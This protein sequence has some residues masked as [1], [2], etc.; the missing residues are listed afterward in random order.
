VSEITLLT[1]EV[2]ASFR[3]ESHLGS[4]GFVLRWGN[5]SWH[6]GGLI[7]QVKDNNIAEFKALETVLEFVQM[8][9]I[10]PTYLLIKCDSQYV[11]DRMETRRPKLAKR[12]WKMIKEITENVE[13]LKIPRR[14]NKAADAMTKF[15]ENRCH[16]DV[17]WQVE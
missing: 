13:L 12:C 6:Q 10:Q 7:G 15:Y 4:Y 17:P 1:I 16:G 14:H 9:K 8:F 2:D 5:E 11:L 3:E